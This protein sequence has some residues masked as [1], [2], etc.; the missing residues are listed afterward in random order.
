MPDEND[1]MEFKTSIT[2]IGTVTLYAKID[3]TI[4]KHLNLI[5]KQEG[6]ATVVNGKIVLDF[7]K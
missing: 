4:A 3:Q 2:K 5:P 7:T 6:T 1:N